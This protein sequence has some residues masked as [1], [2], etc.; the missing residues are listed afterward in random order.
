MP[1]ASPF[2]HPIDATP[3]PIGIKGGGISA[4]QEAHGELVQWQVK[5]SALLSVTVQSLAR[6]HQD[7]EAGTR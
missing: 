4:V 6:L 1:G 7:V 5:P 3:D 2:S